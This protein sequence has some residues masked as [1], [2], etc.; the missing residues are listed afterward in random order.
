[1]KPK[2]PAGLR[3]LLLPFIQ[4]EPGKRPILRF[5][6]ISLTTGALVLGQACSEG[7]HQSLGESTLGSLD[8]GLNLPP[9]TPIPPTPIPPA[10]TPPGTPTTP[11]PPSPPSGPPP[12][13]DYVCK[14]DQDPTPTRLRRLS[15]RQYINTLVDI[16]RG[17][18]S[19]VERYNVG[20]YSLTGPLKPVVGILPGDVRTKHGF[21]TMDQS[22]TEYHAFS[23]FFIASSAADFA[24]ASTSWLS[25]Y[26]GSCL[27]PA[28]TGGAVTDACIDGF[29]D[30]F[31]KMALRKKINAE[32]R[33]FF[34]TLYSDFTNSKDGVAAIIQGMLLHPRF[35]FMVE[36]D[37]TSVN[38][39]ADLLALNDYEIAQRLSF[40]FLGTSP[41]A[42]MLADADAG[43]FTQSEESLKA[44]LA[45]YFATPEN[46]KTAALSGNVYTH[47]VLQ[48]PLEKNYSQ[49]YNEWLEVGKTPGV[50]AGE[51][52]KVF[53]TVY[54]DPQRWTWDTS[55][56]DPFI[57]LETQ[58]FTNLLTWYQDKKF[59]HFL[60]DPTTVY[61]GSLAKFYGVPHVSGLTQHADRAGYL[62]RAAFLLTGDHDTHPFLRG[63]FIR[64]Q[65]LCDQLPS[66]NP[67]ALPDRA[68]ASPE[69]NPLWTNRE[70]YHHKT[71]DVSCTGCHNMINPLA[72]AME[73]FDSLARNRKNM[74]E[75]VFKIEAKPDGSTDV[76]IIG[77]PINN[78][79]V[80]N[81]SL[82]SN[83]I[84]PM[85]NGGI[86]LSQALAKSSKA[87]M[88]F[89]RQIFR[90]TFGRF[91]TN[92]DACMLQSM[93]SNGTAADGSI[94]KMITNA[95]LAKHF[96]LKKIGPR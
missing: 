27:T 96:R 1:M 66:P 71:A 87:N 22:M 33:V 34:K 65:I 48:T 91:E 28:N 93:Y 44:L 78:S 31:G 81:L 17:L 21:A 16:S 25:G 11:V 45:K 41:S 29:I 10:P 37:G 56:T 79:A 49:F 15:N 40:F 57:A 9:G 32:D 39:R 53:S 63:A 43:L 3:S 6:I 68:L 82:G 51:V 88:C 67:D 14:P 90:H 12:N 89:A 60:T 20:W 95:P 80:T 77:K 62:T 69:A 64:R 8:G 36:T 5:V 4:K 38:G 83:E 23:Q 61:G 35:T 94:K 72:F 18:V 59:S 70:R 24:V 92:E 73:D 13:L 42:Q 84:I 2:I 46:S 55:Q 47:P 85:V 7:F 54:N 75:P 52:I 26:G 74:F 58:T 19:Y 76:S 30:K 50:P 86:E